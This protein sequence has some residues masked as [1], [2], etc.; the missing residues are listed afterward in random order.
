M[1][2]NLFLDKPKGKKSKD[3]SQVFRDV[4]LQDDTVYNKVQKI[5]QAIPNE[6]IELS[7]LVFLLGKEGKLLFSALL[8]IIFLIPVSIPGFSTVF[9]AIIFFIAISLLVNQQLWLPKK[10]KKKEIPSDKLKASLTKGLKWFQFIE[11]ISKPHRFKML[12]GN[13]AAY[14]INTISILFGAILL[15][16]PLGFVPFS[17]TLPALAILFLSIGILQ[18]DGGI[19]VLGHLSN[20]ASLIYFSLFFS[21]IAIAVSK[22]LSKIEI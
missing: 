2:K 3:H 9:G 19:I 4:D 5:I 15:M 12:A 16:F 21:T 6:N 1:S 7:E 13:K 20:V 11:R 8:T 17:N 18:K 10:L 14:L 22:I